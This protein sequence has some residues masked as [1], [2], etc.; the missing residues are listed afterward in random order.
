MLPTLLV[1]GAALF[2]TWEVAV[3]SL[4]STSSPASPSDLAARVPPK[5]ATNVA[6]FGAVGN[7][8][9]DDTA[10]LARA[11][12]SGRAVYSDPGKTYLVK[13]WLTLKGTADMRGST[14][15]FVGGSSAGYIGVHASGRVAR[16]S[17]VTIDGSGRSG[18]YVRGVYVGKGHK[19]TASNVR[20]R[21]T[22][23]G[24]TGYGFVVDGTLL[25]TRCNAQ[26]ADYGF[27]VRASATPQTMISGSSSRNGIGLWILGKAGGSVPRF[28]SIDD[29]RFG[30]LL[31]GG[32]SHWRLGEIETSFTGRTAREPTA[33]G[34]E[35]WRDNRYNVVESLVS[36]GNPG[37]ALAFGHDVMYNRIR[38][39]YA[40]GTGAHDNDPGIT[41]TAGASNNR[42]DKATI[43]NYSVGIRIGEDNPKPNNGNRFGSVYIENCGWSG[44]RFEYGSGNRIDSATLVNNSTN[45]SSFP[46]DISFANSVSGNSIGSVTQAGSSSRPTH[47]IYFA[48]GANRNRVEAGSIT[49]FR[50]S[51]VVDANGS[52]IAA[53]R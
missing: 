39:V 42:I 52:N 16:L 51:K 4:G 48:P 34:F 47:G 40:D 53:V 20:T 32:A 49:S 35:F 43:K 2:M 38:V 28:T 30:I 23:G 41:L 10:A 44:I 29:D 26:G 13:T 36:N 19:L 7:G 12:R 17:N 22:R 24:G 3:G 21:D 50:L 8:E 37:Y 46:G 14:I 25:C 33:T 5:G 1:A 18:S 31:D 15:R 45:D 6:R 9:R 11:F 27:Y